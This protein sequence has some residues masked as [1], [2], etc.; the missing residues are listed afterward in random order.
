MEILDINPQQLSGLRHKGLKGAR[1]GH[2]KWIF[3]VEDVIDF[4][5]ANTKQET[6][7]KMTK[8]DE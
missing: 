6:S 3:L 4:L 2:G 7:Q 1:A 8:D 5:K